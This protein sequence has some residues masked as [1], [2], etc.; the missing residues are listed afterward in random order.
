VGI[1][2]TDAAAG[3]LNAASKAVA[4]MSLVKIDLLIS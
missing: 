2:L 4:N 1:W 3:T